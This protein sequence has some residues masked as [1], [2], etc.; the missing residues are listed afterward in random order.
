M[1]T[2]PEIIGALTALRD[3]HGMIVPELVVE[4]ARDESSPLH[5]QFTWDDT[6]AAQAWRIHQARV[7]LRVCVKLL[8]HHSEPVRAFVHLSK[9]NGYR[10]TQTV[11]A[12]ADRRAHLLEDAMRDMRVFRDKYRHLQE[13]AGVF[14]A[15]EQVTQAV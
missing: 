2:S 11:L 12:N 10:E 4:A 15:M 1:I 14:A 3:E 9:E 13:L 5:S 6:E 8:P 7:L